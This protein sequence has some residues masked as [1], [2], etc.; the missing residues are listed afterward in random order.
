[1]AEEGLPRHPYLRATRTELSSGPLLMVSPEDKVQ[2]VAL[3]IAR[4][5]LFLDPLTRQESA[6]WPPPSLHLTE[7]RFYLGLPTPPLSP[8][9]S[10]PRPPG[11]QW[12]HEMERLVASSFM[13]FHSRRECA[14]GSGGGHLC[15][16]IASASF[17]DWA[18][19]VC[20]RAWTSIYSPSVRSQGW[21]RHQTPPPE[22]D[23]SRLTHSAH[24]EIII[25]IISL[26]LKLVQVSI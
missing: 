15:S 4:F 2:T 11:N 21:G 5:P 6:A 12:S 9:P 24:R 25:I 22:R 26:H 19:H 13:C 23:Q 16:G 14:S 3:K 7:K 17:P 8:P 20:V 10:P 18:R 1:M